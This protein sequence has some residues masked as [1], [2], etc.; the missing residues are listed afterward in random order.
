MA[1]LRGRTVTVSRPGPTDYLS[2]YTAI[3]ERIAEV[4]TDDTCG[5]SV[6]ACPG[7]QIHDVLAHLCGLCEDWVNHRLDGYAS[8]GWSAAQVARHADRSCTQI[9]D[10]WANSLSSFGRLREP[11]LGS[12]PARWAFGDAVVHEADIRGALGRGRVPDDAVTLALDGTMARW[13]REVLSRAGLPALHVHADSQDWLLGE[14]GDPDAVV[15]EASLYEV[16]RA[17]AGRRN[18]D[19]VRAWTWSSDPEPYLTAGLPY[20]FHWRTTTLSD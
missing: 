19:Q 20:P 8:E 2:S 11:F 15:V 12:V 7:W 1:A 6:L 14:P 17:L 18:K 10:L 9:L 4:V 5:L 13:H 16:F 3:H